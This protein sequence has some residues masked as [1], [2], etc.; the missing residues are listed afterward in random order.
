M[1]F[2]AGGMG[3]SLGIKRLGCK[4]EAQ[5]EFRGGLILVRGEMGSA[6]NC[7]NSNGA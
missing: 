3:C 6:A 5:W 2:M 7:K 1:L 4:V